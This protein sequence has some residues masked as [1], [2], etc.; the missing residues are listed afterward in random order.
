M[1]KPV[2]GARILVAEDEPKIANLLTDYL[3]QDGFQTH[4]VSDGNQVLTDFESEGADLVLLD[5][6]M[7]GKDGIENCQ[8]IRAIS[9]VPIVM[10]TARVE[11]VDR[12][13]GLNLGADD[14]ICKPFSPREV[15]ARVRAILRRVGRNGQD[16][17]SSP[18]KV[19]E[20]RMQVT[21]DEQPLTLT[22]A[23]FKMLT[24]MI[25]KPGSV[26]SRDHLLDVIDDEP[27]NTSD[28]AIDSHVKNLRKKL[29]LIRPDTKLIASVYG[30]GYKLDDTIDT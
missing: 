25:N 18:F 27:S 22:G 17:T 1:N 20:E 13:L 16:R 5:I 28:R 6:M 2:H 12:L 15:V 3:N 19:D 10:V 30:A 26:F 4:W 14:Y 9:D 7:P 24:A 21:L 29:S 11:E 23:E 8:A